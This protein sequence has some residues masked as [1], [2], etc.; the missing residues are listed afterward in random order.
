M[1]WLYKALKVISFLMNSDYIVYL[2][3]VYFRAG[4]WMFPLEPCLSSMVCR[5]AVQAPLE[6]LFGNSESLVLTH[7]GIRLCILLSSSVIHV[8][9][10]VGQTL[11]E[12]ILY[13]SFIWGWRWLNPAALHKTLGSKTVS[14][15]VIVEGS[16]FSLLKCFKDG[17]V[18]LREPKKC[19]WFT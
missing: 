11:I 6:T 9:I 4:D 1:E 15:S 13:F 8:H 16:G 10:R 19:S 2:C 18:I 14:F 17:S 3:C 5:P 7:S 12:E